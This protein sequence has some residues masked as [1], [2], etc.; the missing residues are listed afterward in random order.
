MRFWDIA[1]LK[2]FIEEYGNIYDIVKR[3]NE[4]EYQNPY[5]TKFGFF[6]SVLYDRFIYK[7]NDRYKYNIVDLDTEYQK[8]LSPEIWNEYINAYENRYN[9]CCGIYE[10]FSQF[11]NKNN[12]ELI[13]KLYLDNH[14]NIVRMGEFKNNYQ[15]QKMFINMVKPN[16]LT[17]SQ[18][19]SFGLNVH[20]YLLTKLKI[21]KNISRINNNIKRFLFPIKACIKWILNIFMLVYNIFK[22]FIDI[23]IG[24]LKK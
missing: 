15:Y 22:F 24:S 16:I 5:Q 21:N 23:I 11:L 9:G 6:E 4:Y 12:T 7:H 18:E 1:I 13:A 10:H 3:I 8:Y 20:H 14:I 2:D 19:H 17:C